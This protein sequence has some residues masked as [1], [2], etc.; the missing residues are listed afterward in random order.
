MFTPRRRSYVRTDTVFVLSVVP[1]LHCFSAK[2]T[3]EVSN[4]TALCERMHWIRT[5]ILA[6][7]AGPVDRRTP[8]GPVPRFSLSLRLNWRVCVLRILCKGFVLISSHEGQCCWREAKTTMELN[9]FSTELLLSSQILH[10]VGLIVIGAAHE[11]HAFYKSI[12]L[13]DTFTHITFD[14]WVQWFWHPVKMFYKC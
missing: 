14:P 6:H 2:W 9:L 5:K 13:L 12:N 11:T 7:C 8:L 1:S 4:K 3:I 10:N